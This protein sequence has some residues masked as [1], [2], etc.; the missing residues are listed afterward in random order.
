MRQRVREKFPTANPANFRAVFQRD[1]GL[2]EIGLDGAGP[3]ESRG[4]AEA[5]ASAS[6]DPPDKPPKRR[7]PPVVS[8]RPYRKALGQVKTPQITDPLAFR[9][10]TRI[11][12]VFRLPQAI[13]AAIAPLVFAR[14]S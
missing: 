5:V 3:F 7:R 12:R 9:Q 6:D 2:F 4:F 13:A 10:A 1:D 14:V 8:G 11:A